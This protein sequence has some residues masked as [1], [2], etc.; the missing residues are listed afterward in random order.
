MGGMDASNLSKIDESILAQN[1]LTATDVY[2]YKASQKANTWK[3]GLS[4]DTIKQVSSISKEFY[5]STP[6][7]KFDLMQQAYLDT[8]A[9]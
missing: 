9:V 1:N 3:A 5:D 7:K 8:K 4:D 6:A 2:N